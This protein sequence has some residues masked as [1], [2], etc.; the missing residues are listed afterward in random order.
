M[1]SIATCWEIA[2]KVGLGKL[3]LGEPAA[4]YIPNALEKSLIEILPITISHATTVESLPYHHKDPFDRMLVAQSKLE[5][6]MIVSRD[7]IF[8]L[9][10]LSRIW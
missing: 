4:T 2:I 6:L 10:G 1:I 5:N 7:A 9:Y 3:N 8:D